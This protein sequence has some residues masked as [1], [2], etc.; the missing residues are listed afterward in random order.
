MARDHNARLP[1][2][3]ARWQVLV[4]KTTTI[5]GDDAKSVSHRHV[6]ASALASYGRY[7]RA[8]PSSGSQ[9]RRRVEFYEDT[10]HTDT[11]RLNTLTTI[12][13][14]YRKKY[15]LYLFFALFVF[16]GI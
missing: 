5:H 7:I 3:G 9:Q 6:P 13:E 14:K 11:F 8:E 1:T 4:V 15:T 10:I 12:R 16:S 2:I